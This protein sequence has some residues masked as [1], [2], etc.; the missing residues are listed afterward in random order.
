MPLRPAARGIFFFAPFCLP[1][2]ISCLYAACLGVTAFCV[3]AC[4]AAC[5]QY[6]LTPEAGRINAWAKAE[7]TYARK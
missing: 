6:H 1:F 3:L 4:V 2:G 7:K 5:R